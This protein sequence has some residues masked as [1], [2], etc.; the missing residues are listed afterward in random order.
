M[1]ILTGLLVMHYRDYYSESFRSDL[2]ELLSAHPQ[3]HDHQGEDL[4]IQP[5]M[6]AADAMPIQTWRDERLRLFTTALFYTVLVDQ[7][8][9]TYFQPSYGRWRSLT[10]YP[11][12][13]GDCPAACR[14]N[15]DPREAFRLV[16]RRSGDS[17]GDAPA[18]ECA[19]EMAEARS[20]MEAEVLEFFL[21][22]MP[23]V[24]GQ[25]FWELCAMHL[26]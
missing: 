3:P 26:P 5:C 21:T 18:I 10:M 25:R 19:A 12:L 7:V 23:E 15:L 22:H 11:K 13:H 1:R 6:L 4:M 24:D 8:A 20:V 17:Y 9:Y 2:R 14:S 16:P